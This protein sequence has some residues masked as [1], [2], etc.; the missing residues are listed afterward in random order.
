MN[1]AS[2]GGIAGVYAEMQGQNVTTAVA[3]D[4]GRNNQTQ[5]A[6]LGTPT[7]TYPADTADWNNSVAV[8]LNIQKRL[9]FSAMF[10]TIEAS[11]LMLTMRSPGRGEYA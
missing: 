3:T 2:S 11:S 7:I 10:M 1:A 5:I 9:N 4:V 8:T 6:L